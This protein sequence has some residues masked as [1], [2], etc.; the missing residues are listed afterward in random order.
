M[1]EEIA[2]AAA[3]L[4]T[5]ERLRSELNALAL[6]VKALSDQASDLQADRDHWTLE[7]RK[8]QRALHDLRR[9]IIQMRK[10]GHELPGSLFEA[11]IVWEEHTHA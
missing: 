3:D 6:Q 9:T 2:T 7:A 4:A 1:S 10:A 5:I 11:S 8:A